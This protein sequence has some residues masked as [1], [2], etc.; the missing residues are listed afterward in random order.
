M[1]MPQGAWASDTNKQY[2]K[3]MLSGNIMRIVFEKRDGTERSL[4]CTRDLGLVAEE[5]HPKGV[6]RDNPDVLPVWSIPDAGWRSFRFDRV[7]HV[8]LIT[9]LN[10]DN[11]V[12]A[13]DALR[14]GVLLD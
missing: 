9:E 10:N 4:I 5:N 7:R 2:L 1:T 12:V 8:T 14:S 6:K 13:E 3:D 11:A